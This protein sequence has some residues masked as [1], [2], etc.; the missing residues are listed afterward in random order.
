MKKLHIFLLTYF[1]LAFGLAVNS[2]AAPLVLNGSVVTPTATIFKEPKDDADILTNLSKD[3]KID[4]IGNTIDYKWLQVYYQPRKQG[5]IKREK[6][7][8]TVIAPDFDF[9]KFVG[10]EKNDGIL[11]K[12]YLIKTFNNFVYVLDRGYPDKILKFNINGDYVS[13]VPLNYLW[14][15]TDSDY[16]DVVL[17]ID[18]NENIY[19]NSDAQNILNQYS[20]DG[21][22]KT[23]II[24]EGISYLKDLF[25]SVRNKR[26]Y[27]LDSNDKTVKIFSPDG[28]FIKFVFLE[29]AL[30]PQK[31]SLDENSEKIYVLDKTALYD[32]YVVN[33]EVLNVRVSPSTDAAIMA[34]LKTDSF[35]KILSDKVES[36]ADDRYK[37]KK[38]EI[39][40]DKSGYVA[41]DFIKKIKASGELQIYSSSGEVK[42]AISLKK[43][44]NIVNEN[45]PLYTENNNFTRTITDINYSNFSG[46][47]MSINSS[48]ENSEINNIN[49]C[50]L[51]S[52]LLSF[53]SFEIINGSDK[54]KL[55]AGAT[56]VLAINNS[57]SISVF[58][59][60]GQYIKEMGRTSGLKPLFIKILGTTSDNN[61]IVLDIGT[62]SIYLYD[63]TAGIKK[64]INLTKEPLTPK[65]YFYLSGE[66]ISNILFGE[67]LIKENNIVR[68]A[69]Y[70]A[71]GSVKYS[72][73]LPVPPFNEIIM[74]INNLDEK[75]IMTKGKLLG[76]NILQILDKNN[77]PI[78]KIR[79]KEDL[80]ALFAPEEIK[81]MKIQ[82]LEAVAI[83]QKGY[84]YFKVRDKKADRYL[85]H[86]FS[87]S[88]TEP[89]KLIDKLN[90]YELLDPA[91]EIK[92]IMRS[93][94]GFTYILFPRKIAV[95]SPLGNLV[96]TVEVKKDLQDMI[97][98]KDNTVFFA[99]YFG[100]YKLQN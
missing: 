40:E 55:C 47:T 32:A 72:R 70:D 86:R 73:S 17:A 14:P 2:Y 57:G 21:K 42:S 75:I 58:N 39:S 49:I 82:D 33:T 92:K 77:N 91:A 18:E 12:P 54:A 4:I 41:F 37:W 81:G 13:S 46:L 30:N 76:R 1:L 44:I 38:I 48:M 89:G 97:M 87:I 45:F 60:E 85:L 98:D 68:L 71:A 5:W 67:V 64:E 35:V 88:S 36:K 51:S 95:F 74:G 90:L 16:D 65:N 23:V 22:V 62:N 69:G 52:D 84:I 31:I 78:R 19:T 28:K 26:I 34:T 29:Q 15:K 10:N 83:D 66:S 24:K 94:Y 93:D 7:T 63:E 11:I 56:R 9:T 27:C 6:I 53:N 25:Y 96:K 99:D 3:A 79:I 43:T 100:I 59:N 20:P 80:V 8:Y 61:I 50:K